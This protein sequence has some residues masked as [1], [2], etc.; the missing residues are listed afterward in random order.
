[1]ERL[2]SLHEN[3]LKLIEIMAKMG[4]DK[5]M[6]TILMAAYGSCGNAFRANTLL[7]AMKD[8]RVAPTREIYNLL[9]SINGKEGGTVCNSYPFSLLLFIVCQLFSFPLLDVFQCSQALLHP[10]YS[11]S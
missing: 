8:S 4:K 11:I 3:D 7:R 9:I 1:V 2:D 6:Y 5:R 10:S